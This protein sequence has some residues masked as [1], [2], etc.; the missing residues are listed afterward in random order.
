MFLSAVKVKNML[1]ERVVLSERG[2]LLRTPSP[3]KSALKNCSPRRVIF[4]DLR[5]LPPVKVHL[6]ISNILLQK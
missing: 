5:V 6:I 2:P 4:M 3:R 1:K